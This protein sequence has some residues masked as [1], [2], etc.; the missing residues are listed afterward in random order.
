[1]LRLKEMCMVFTALIKS[2]TH[3]AIS[4]KSCVICIAGGTVLKSNFFGVQ[5]VGR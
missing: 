5:R 2:Y 3:K 4:W 1:M